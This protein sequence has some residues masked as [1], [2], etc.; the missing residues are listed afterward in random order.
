M[1]RDALLIATKDLKIE[2]RSK[3]TLNLILPFAFVVLIIFAFALDTSP[4]TLQKVAPGLFWLAVLFSS[5]FSVDRAVA[6]ESDDNAGDGLLVYGVDPG[7]IFLGKVISVFVQL[8]LLEIFLLLG[9]VVLYGPKIGGWLLMLASAL[10]ATIGLCAAGV[11]YSQLASGS[12]AK[13][14]LLP[15]LLV[16]VV[17]PV[18]LAA[19][20]A[21]QDAFAAA[22]S[23]EDPWLRLLIVFAVVY[24]ALGAIFYS[25][26]LEG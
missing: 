17:S 22:S 10:F 1:W 11:T 24:L 2:F 6:I 15:L 20:K 9:V 25:S 26:I 5:I 14:T 13:Q 4:G 18:L 8:F 3:V 16:P 12:R 23:L 7:G 19:T 21:W